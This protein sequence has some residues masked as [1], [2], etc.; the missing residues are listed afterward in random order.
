MI[1]QYVGAR[2]VPKFASPVEWASNTS[3]EAL[4]IVTFNNASYTSKV[5]VPP[6]VGNPANNPQYWALTGNYN[7]QVEQYRQETVGY[8]TQVDGYKQE[9]EQYKTQVEEY[10]NA[11]NASIANINDGIAN[12]NARMKYQLTNVIA[13]GDSYATESYSWPIQ[14]NNFLKLPTTNYHVVAK[15]GYGFNDHLD[16]STAL[17]EY[18]D[19]LSATDKAKVDAIICCCGA[20]D[21]GISYDT[22]N[23][24]FSRFKAITDT[25]PNARVYIG[26]IGACVP[27][28]VTDSAWKNRA[29]V[30]NMVTTEYNYK[31][32]AADRRFF[33]LKD[34]HKWAQSGYFNSEY[35]HPNANGSVEIASK[36]YS[37]I[38]GSFLN[39]TWNINFSGDNV[40]KIPVSASI[41]KCESGVLLN[42]KIAGDLQTA[43]TIGQTTSI[44]S[45]ATLLPNGFTTEFP[46]ILRTGSTFHSGFYKI[47]YNEGVFTFVNTVLN[48]GGTDWLY[49]NV[50]SYLETSNTYSI[51][52]V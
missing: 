26:M 4:T 10:K 37:S 12:I 36:I 22:I 14:L 11:A 3:Y 42:I 29:S 18:A 35:V 34:S 15:S 30:A 24:A 50:N 28:L 9:T 52:Y 38:Y 33:Y 20:N 7:A 2:Y 19:T 39:R 16:I 5:P 47:T 46:V 43:S 31:A 44:K 40:S 8:K 45:D 32:C 49:D 17:K 48:T 1:R 25:F 23:S 13:V 41:T 27:T 21:F 6:T 51:A